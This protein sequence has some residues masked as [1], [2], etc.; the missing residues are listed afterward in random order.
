MFNEVKG[1]KHS[2]FS[3]QYHL[4]LVTKYRKRAINEDVFLTISEVIQQIF[5]K[6]QC[7][8]LT[9]N[10]DYDHI[11]VLFFCYSTSPTVTLG[12]QHKN[13]YK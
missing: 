2:R 1:N 3:L 4:V 9:L 10:H 12:E 13:R 8:L 11:H 6:N 5:Q 7:E